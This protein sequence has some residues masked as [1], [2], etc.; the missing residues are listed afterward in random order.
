MREISLKIAGFS[1]YVADHSNALVFG[2]NDCQSK[3]VWFPPDSCQLKL[4]ARTGIRP[5]FSPDE[6]LFESPTGYAV[7]RSGQGHLLIRGRSAPARSLCAEI[8]PTFRTGVLFVGPQDVDAG[9][10]F[11][12]L[13]T[14]DL[15]MAMHRFAHAD[16]VIV[17][18]AAV[19]HEGHGL[20]FVGLAGAGKSTLAEL[21][22]GD[23]R[24]VVLG[25]DTAVVTWQDGAAWVC[26]TPWHEN[27]ARCAAVEVPLRAAF[28]VD[29]GVENRASR[30]GP[31]A[32]TAGLLGNCLL[33]LYD[34]GAMQAILATFEKLEACLPVYRLAFRPDRSAVEYLLEVV[35][36]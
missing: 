5:P 18:A 4:E 17:H 19:A 16:S 25:E 9:R 29:H 31:S 3:F 21:W 24:S 8:D 12:P 33:P 20:L 34:R 32:G 13:Q 27:P 15:I 1:F 10:P 6:T 2:L 36:N 28:L 26:G 23:P 11:Y 30:C 14:I 7:G 22:S 35:G